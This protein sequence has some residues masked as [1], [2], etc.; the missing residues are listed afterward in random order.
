M[1]KLPVVE[2]SFDEHAKDLESISL[3]EVNSLA[4]LQTRTDRKYLLA[5]AQ[6][7]GLLG[8]WHEEHADELRVVEH[9]GVRGSNYASCYFDTPELLCYKMALQKARRR[10]KVRSRTYVDS[11]LTFMEVKLKSRLGT[12]KYRMLCSDDQVLPQVAP[13]SDF[14]RGHIPVETPLEAFAPSLSINYVRTTLVGVGN[15]DEA[16]FRV[17]FDQR[18]T[19]AANGKQI[20]ANPSFI[21]ETKTEGHPSVVD[22]KLWESGIRPM[23]VSKYAV[24]MALLNPALPRQRWNRAVAFLGKGERT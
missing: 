12:D 21:V 6:A 8:W 16:A 23:P 15:T 2:L 18:L 11:D 9:A 3:D 13:T 7:A 14:V 20:R 4:S 1:N 22:R 10:F 17:T 5:P 19:W 24:G